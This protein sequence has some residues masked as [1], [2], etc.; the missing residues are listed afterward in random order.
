MCINV[1]DRSVAQPIAHLIT[2]NFT[3]TGYRFELREKHFGLN[4]KSS[5]F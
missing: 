3:F 4:L 1:K 5:H 2:R